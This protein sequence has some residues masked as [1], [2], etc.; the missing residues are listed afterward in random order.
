M[1]R[2]RHS[3]YRAPS[4]RSFIRDVHFPF[5]LIVKERSRRLPVRHRCWC[6]LLLRWHR[7]LRVSSIPQYAQRKRQ[8]ETETQRRRRFRE[9]TDTR[10]KRSALQSQEYADRRRRSRE[11]VVTDAE[12]YITRKNRLA[13]RRKPTLALNNNS[14]RE[15]RA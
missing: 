3:F 10:E 15:E 8:R 6:A 9:T 1:L 5:Y 12:T 4:L 14:L 11:A 7:S 2:P 13:I